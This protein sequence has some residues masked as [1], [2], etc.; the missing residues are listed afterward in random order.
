MTAEMKR[1]GSSHAHL[2]TGPWPMSRAHH[3][4]GQGPFVTKDNEKQNS[5]L[6]TFRKYFYKLPF[7]FS[8]FIT[9][10]GSGNQ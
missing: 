7:T 1:T 3:V 6:L 10:L 4:P 8:R 5:S 2:P 9:P